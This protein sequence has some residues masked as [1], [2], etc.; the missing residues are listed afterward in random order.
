MAIKQTENPALSAKFQNDI[1]E[2]VL[3][4]AKNSKLLQAFISAKR[5]TFT[6]DVETGNETVQVELFEPSSDQ[7]S[8]L[9]QMTTKVLL[10]A[11]EVGGV[12]S[13][14]LSETEKITAV[15][16]AYQSVDEF[17]ET[18]NNLLAEVTVDPALDYDAFASGLIPQKIRDQVLAGIRTWG[19]KQKET[20]SFRGKRQRT[21]PVCAAD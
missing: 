7:V 10:A 21:K 4:N 1:R 8:W 19:A 13:S 20:E 6:I 3:G 2:K 11:K 12:T 5:E 17:N 15:L 14:D 18:V 9:N 16:G